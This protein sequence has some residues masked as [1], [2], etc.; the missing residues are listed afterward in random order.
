[1]NVASVSVLSQT[2]TILKTMFNS[3]LISIL[4]LVFTASRIKK[5]E[6]FIVAFSL[7]KYIFSLDPFFLSFFL[8]ASRISKKMKVSFIVH[9]C[10]S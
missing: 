2:P 10:E 7:G 6:R 5:K 1:M 8:T 4:V 9:F 3:L